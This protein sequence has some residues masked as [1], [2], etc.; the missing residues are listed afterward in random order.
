MKKITFLLILTLGLFVTHAQ[1]DIS[2]GSYFGLEYASL[3]TDLKIP[4]ATQVSGIRVADPT[5]DAFVFRVGHYFTN[6]LAAEFHLGTSLTEE[7]SNGTGEAKMSN[8][9]SL[10]V[11][12]NL[13][14]HAQNTNL[15][16]LLG[17]SYFVL[18]LTDSATALNPSGVTK[19]SASGVSY[20]FGVELYATPTTA[21]NIEYV[22]YLSED[23][24]DVGGFSLGFIKHFTAP[25]LF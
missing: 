18:K 21:V 9:V 1:A 7:N 8:L 22:R 15:Y 16:V 12:G 17:G 5:L 2:S 25:K 6:Y 11:R 20:A 13:P 10:F 19:I 24:V 3:D 23:D 4:D 14:L